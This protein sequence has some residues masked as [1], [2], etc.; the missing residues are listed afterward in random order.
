MSPTRSHQ[1]RLGEH[2]QLPKQ[3]CSLL[4]GWQEKANIKA[5]MLPAQGLV[6]RKPGWQHSPERMKKIPE[7]KARMV[8]WGR[9]WPMLLRMKPMNMKKR[10][11][12]GKGVA[13]RIIS[14]GRSRGKWE[15][16]NIP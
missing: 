7:T 4:K 9:M 6:R 12:R 15:Q 13:E 11:T 2:Q 10:L 14:G 1:G 3:T 5:N 16:V 8:L